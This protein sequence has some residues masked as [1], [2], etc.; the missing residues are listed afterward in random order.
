MVVNLDVVLIDVNNHLCWLFT[1][2]NARILGKLLSKLS[3]DHIT[4][5]VVFEDEA[6]SGDCTLF[7]PNTS[8]FD[9]VIT[10]FVEFHCLLT[11]NL[12]SLNQAILISVLIEYD[13][14][15]LS[16]NLCNSLP[17]V[18]H[19]RV[20]VLHSLEIEWETSSNS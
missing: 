8:I 2:S 19:I 12:Y 13:L 16:I 1:C 7:E 18:G 9:T 5:V 10:L 14:S 3:D 15:N 6:I 11:N 20:E 17:I 4:N